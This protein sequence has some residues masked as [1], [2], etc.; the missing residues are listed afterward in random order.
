LPL[1]IPCLCSQ[2]RLTLTCRLPQK[3]YLL[4]KSGRVSQ[5]QLM[6][7]FVL[8][9]DRSIEIFANPKVKVGYRLYL[10]LLLINAAFRLCD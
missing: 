6:R 2:V 1:F 8:I 4:Q 9:P 5:A 7:I 3:I 10:V